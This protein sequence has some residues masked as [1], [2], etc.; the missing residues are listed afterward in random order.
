[1]LTGL[2]PH[3]GFKT[4]NELISESR[5][6]GL[7][8]ARFVNP[9][10]P[11][12]LDAIAAK[13]L[14]YE[15]GRRYPSPLALRLDV[16][17]WLDDRS[18][19]CLKDSLTEKLIR[20]G[21]RNR[22]VTVTLFFCSLILTVSAVIGGFIYRDIANRER[23]ASADAAN[24]R[25]VAEQATK[26]AEDAAEIAIDANRRSSETL[27]AASQSELNEANRL[28]RESYLPLDEPQRTS[29]LDGKSSWHFGIA[30]LL[31]AIRLDPNNTAAKLRLY[32]SLVHQGRARRSIPKHIVEFDQGTQPI[33]SS[34]GRYLLVKKQG[35]YT[36]IDLESA[37]LK[38]EPLPAGITPGALVDGD[39]FI[40]CFGDS[41]R[42]ID[43]QTFKPILTL[44]LKL[45]HQIAISTDRKSLFF[46]S[47]QSKTIRRFDWSG[48]EIPVPLPPLDGQD[49]WI[50]P[51]ADVVF[52]VKDKSLSWTNILTGLTNRI[53]LPYLMSGMVENPLI[54]GNLGRAFV[55][56]V[57]GDFFWTAGIS[58]GLFVLPAS[59]K[60]TDSLKPLA[61]LPGFIPACS[62]A[63]TC[64][65]GNQIAIA[66]WDGSLELLQLVTERNRMPQ[67]FNREPSH[68]LYSRPFAALLSRKI[69]CG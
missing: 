45:F 58:N 62:T 29:R 28:I 64:S 17:A 34:N 63:A 4:V 69:L 68:R 57:W 12:A 3:H 18:V 59:A 24:K 21:R 36:K 20:L 55:A 19:S 60:S 15:Q 32:D 27:A 11:R 31:N 41:L 1:M 13:C 22:G 14:E 42:I 16:E 7:P 50:V 43:S 25:I 26:R 35:I 10:V 56:P 44:P 66:W 47:G 5:K 49:M 37:T 54:K 51:E 65:N 9:A 8:R 23:A 2:P 46:L 48:N 67:S 6:N 33:Y 38:S 30:H 53:E 39:K 52:S 40:A 61:M